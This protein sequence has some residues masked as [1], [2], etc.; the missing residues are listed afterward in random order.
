MS[1]L[2]MF[3]LL[4]TQF[5]SFYQSSLILFA[6]VLSTAGVLIGLLIT[7]NPFS[8][9]LS[10]VGVVALAGIV[11]N[12]NIVLIDT[13]NEIRDKNPDMNYVDLIVR[14]GAQRFRPVMLTTITTVFGLMPLASNLS[15]D[16]V[17]RTIEYGS[18]LSTFWVPLSQAIVS[19]LTF[20]TL[21]TLVTTPAMLALP[22]QIKGIYQRIRNSRPSAA[23][24]RAAE[25]AG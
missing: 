3:V 18:M 1:L 11:V 25:S 19:G 24:Q 2:L 21:L 12:N 4:V 5:N 14:T 10:G 20:A 15:I 16:F 13:Y 17:N 7:G 23:K 6:V 9:I 22:H 8:A